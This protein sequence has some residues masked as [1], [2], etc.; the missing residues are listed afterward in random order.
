MTAKKYVAEMVT[1]VIVKTME[2]EIT[3]NAF[4]KNHTVQASDIPPS[5]NAYPTLKVTANALNANTDEI[6]RL[7][8]VAKAVAGVSQSAIRKVLIVPMV[9][10]TVKIMEA[11]IRI[12]AYKRNQ[13]VQSLD[14][15][16]TTSA[17][18]TLKGTENVSNAKTVGM[19]H[20]IAPIKKA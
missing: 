2:V 4:S 10:A 18:P 11:Q 15:L 13:T 19:A 16:P 17:Y 9:I 7:L 3:T 5:I 14:I 1:I 8:M 6:M 20:I 12:I